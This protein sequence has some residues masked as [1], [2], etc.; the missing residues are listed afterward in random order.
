MAWSYKRESSF[1]AIPEGDYR[2][3]VKNAEKATSKAG[4]DMVT[5]QFDVSGKSQSLFY[6]IVFN[7]EH[8]EWTNRTLTSFFDAFPGIPEGDFNLANWIGKTGACRV[9]HEE[10]NGDTTAKVHYFIRASKQGSLPAWQEPPK[11]ADPSG[12]GA[13]ASPAAVVDSDGFM[14]VD[15][16]L[17]EMDFFN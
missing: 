13:T 12:G 3:R 10:Y 7:N 4:R 15:E 5:L 2:I 9:K 1:D 11:K 14:K 8:P 6:Y 17:D 16:N